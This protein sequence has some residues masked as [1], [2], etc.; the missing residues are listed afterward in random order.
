MF[1]IKKQIRNIYAISAFGS[2]QIAGASWV[3]LLAARGF[4]LVEIGIAESVFHVASLLF[5]IPSGVISDVFGRK[6]SMIMSQCMFIISALFMMLSESM[7]GVYLA[8]VLDAL[9][10]NFASG[11]REALA[12]DSLKKAGEEERYDKYASTEMTI[13]RIG[14]ASATLCA[15]LAL[16]IGYKKAYFIDIVLGVLCLY[17]SFS[18]K[19]VLADEKKSDKNIAE[20]IL[21]C[22]K[23]SVGFLIHNHR[24]T[25]L[26][27][28]NA[29]IGA[30]ATLV[31]FFLQAEL[32]EAGV[33][34][35]LLGPALFVI[36]LGGAAGAKLVQ[37]FSGWKYS[38]ISVM[39]VLGVVLGALSVVTGYPLIMC[40]GGFVASLFDDLLQVRSDILLNQM[41]PSS[42]RATLISVAS[43][44]FSVVMIVLSPAMGWVFSLL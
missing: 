41:I 20:R 1:N 38:K 26:M 35:S 37:Y 22:V 32:K 12:Y 13:Y 40:L 21:K 16:V 3:V 28:W 36:G 14:N 33:T 34:E 23:E 7:A 30:I 18:L 9:G 8:L 25:R 15:G 17:F 29:F 10:Y 19:E 44:C 27:L 6:K 43:L 24:A 4:S 11:A 42:Q 5:E 31:C 2:F 39:C